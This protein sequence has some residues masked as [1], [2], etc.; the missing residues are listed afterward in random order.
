MSQ[1]HLKE[2]GRFISLLACR[3]SLSIDRRMFLDKAIKDMAK[4]AGGIELR[5]YDAIVE[6]TRTLE[7]HNTQSPG[8]DLEDLFVDEKRGLRIDKDPSVRQKTDM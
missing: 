5:K 2:K 6:A 7:G 1:E 4:R 3:D 8:I